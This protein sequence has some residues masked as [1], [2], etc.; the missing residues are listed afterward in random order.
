MCA[1]MSYLGLGTQ[2]LGPHV[3]VVSPNFHALDD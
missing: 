1:P 2:Y 3:E